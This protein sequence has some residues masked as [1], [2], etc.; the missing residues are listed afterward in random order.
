MSPVRDSIGFFDHCAGPLSASADYSRNTVLCKKGG[1]G[2][3]PRKGE[4][5][6]AGNKPGSVVDNHSSGTTVTDRL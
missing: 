4:K 2:D 3:G 6:R 1:C 5:A